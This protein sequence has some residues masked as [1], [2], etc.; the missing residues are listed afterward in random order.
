MVGPRRV[1]RK[2][3]SVPRALA[4]AAAIARRYASCRRNL[5]RRRSARDAG[6]MVSLL[7]AVRD[8]AAA[9]VSRNRRRRV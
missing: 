3:L 4:C 1:V 5:K 7:D 9:D 2:T 8:P 6:L